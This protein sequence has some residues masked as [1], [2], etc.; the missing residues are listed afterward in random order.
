MCQCLATCISPSYFSTGRYRRG[1]F[2][3]E[4]AD[5]GDTAEVVDV[6]L[7]RALEL[8]KSWNV[9]KSV[10]AQKAA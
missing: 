1:L 7:D 6:Q 2:D 5:G 3:S 8:L 10:V 4:D 9:F